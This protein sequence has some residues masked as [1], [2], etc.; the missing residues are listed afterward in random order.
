[1]ASRFRVPRREL[2]NRY[3]LQALVPSSLGA[4]AAEMHGQDH[5][6]RHLLQPEL[7]GALRRHTRRSNAA[8]LR[9][10]LASEREAHLQALLQPG[11]QLTLDLAD[12]A[13]AAFGL[14]PRYPFFDRR[15]IEFCLG[16]PDEQKFAGGWPRLLLRRAM[17]GILP[18]EIQWRTTK[19]NLSPNF[20]R[21]FRDVD[22]ARPER[23]DD[24]SLSPYLQ[25]GPLRDMIARQRVQAVG[26]DAKREA[27]TLFRATVLAEWL[28]SLTSSIEPRRQ[29]A[30]V[31]SPAA[32]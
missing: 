11:Y 14:E 4:L 32:A 7:V 25:S 5:P 15:L 18:P 10:P 9:R 21:R 8:D 24:A 12:R 3:G 2:V 1:M 22:L 26:D 17:D 20:H 13:A 19:S 23:L 29:E 6:A 16:L 27:L 28:A 31:P 30:R